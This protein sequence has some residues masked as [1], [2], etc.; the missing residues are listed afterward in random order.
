MKSS[1]LQRIDTWNK[2]LKQGQKLPATFVFSKYI[3]D[4]HQ[5]K[6]QKRFSE[7][8]IIHNV[9]FQVK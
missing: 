8:C 3:F 4:K 1:L 6:I 2:L 7:Y 5:K 9:K